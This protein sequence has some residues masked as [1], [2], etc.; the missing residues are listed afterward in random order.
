MVFKEMLLVFIAQC[1][2]VPRNEKRHRF[3]L[4]NNYDYFVE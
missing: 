3:K 2:K 4:N 1:V